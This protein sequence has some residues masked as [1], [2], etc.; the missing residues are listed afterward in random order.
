MSKTVAK[1][2]STDSDFALFAYQN[3]Q[4]CKSRSRATNTTSR[5]GVNQTP[6]SINI[7]ELM[8]TFKPVE[9]QEPQQRSLSMI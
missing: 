9:H 8:T 5:V 1:P 7:S 3:G 4:S 2:K 6:H